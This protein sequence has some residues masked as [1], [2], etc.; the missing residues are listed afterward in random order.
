M[1]STLPWM[2][3]R[4]S[5]LPWIVPQRHVVGLPPVIE[6]LRLDPVEMTLPCW[7]DSLCVEHELVQPLFRGLQVLS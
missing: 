4:F 3:H 1:A 6:K 2:Q 5:L 7:P